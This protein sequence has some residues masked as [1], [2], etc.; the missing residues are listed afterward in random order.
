MVTVDCAILLEQMVKANLKR[1]KN[2]VCFSKENFNGI[3]LSFFQQKFFVGK[4]LPPH[5]RYKQATD[6]L[7]L[8]IDEALML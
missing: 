1:L 7:E 6:K 8:M 3:F 4:D 2:P 5:I